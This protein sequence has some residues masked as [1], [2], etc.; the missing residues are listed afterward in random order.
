MAGG[1]NT[2]DVIA[3]GDFCLVFVDRRREGGEA[4]DGERSRLVSRIYLS[5]RVKER[6]GD[7]IIIFI[8]YNIY[9][10]A[11]GGAAGGGTSTQGEKRR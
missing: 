5:F 10:I 2:T 9:I 6:N 8:S 11:C 7:N 3:L 1:A 4:L